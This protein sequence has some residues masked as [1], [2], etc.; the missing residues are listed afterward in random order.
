MKLAYSSN[1][2]RC[3]GLIEAI[4]HVAELGYTGIEIMADV[5]HAWP[6]ATGSAEIA[7]IQ[8]ALGKHGLAISNVNA[9]MMNAVQ[10]FWHP[11]WIELDDRIRQKRIDH[12]AAALHLAAALGA[13]SITTEPGGPLEEGMERL[14]AMETFVAGLKK[15]LPLAEDL[16]VDLLVEPEPG[17]LIENSH[18]FAELAAQI[19]SPAFGLNFDVGHFYCVAEP[20]PETIAKMR[21]WTRHYHFEDIAGDRVHEHLVPGHGAIDFQAVL[22]AVAGT[23]YDGWLTVELYPYL[24][25]PDAAGAEAKLRLEWAMSRGK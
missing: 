2:Y 17:L 11:S 4:E 8:A 9:F 6:A 21:A 14:W 22:N 18:Q 24:D 12:T 5:P 15:V 13:P 1:A 23:G 19:D 3:F 25:D 20:L 16:G 7:A 10:D